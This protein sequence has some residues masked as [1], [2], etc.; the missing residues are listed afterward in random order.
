MELHAATVAAIHRMQQNYNNLD[1]KERAKLE[2]VA[3]WSTQIE[4][5]GE[6]CNMLSFFESS[7]VNGL[8]HRIAS[9]RK[10][11]RQRYQKKMKQHKHYKLV[12]IV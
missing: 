3:V 7:L 4:K 1:K 9:F 8:Q 2:Q 11:A 6:C 10:S 5:F 12:V